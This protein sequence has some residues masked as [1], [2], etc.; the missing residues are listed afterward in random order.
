LTERLY[1]EDSYATS[2]RSRVYAVTQRGDTYATELQAT[3]F[4]PESGSQPSDTG[5][6]DDLRIETVVEDGDTVLHISTRRPPFGPG[7][8]VDGRIDWDRRFA[9]MQQHT[10]QHILS[11]A[12]VQELDARTVSSKLGIESS[13][14]DV[15]CLGLDWDEIERAER[16][17]NAIVFANLAVKV[18]SARAGEVDGL[19]Y[20]LELADQILAREM[21][22][23]VEIEGFDK[24]PCGG[25]HCRM[26]GEV[27]LIKVLR[28]EKVRET[29]RVEFVCG[30]LA[31]VDYFWKNR[32]VVDLARQLTTK[33][34][35]VPGR[36]QNLLENNKE[37][38]FRI[39]GLNKKLLRYEAVELGRGARRV[40]NVRLVCTYL[41]RK[42]EDD[43]R[44]LAGCLVGGAG[45][46][47]LLACGKTAVHFIFAR[48]ADVTCDMRK[49]IE[50]ACRVVGGR[51]GGKPDFCEGG[52]K[53]V[54]RVTEALGEAEHLLGEMLN[55]IA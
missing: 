6:I 4:Y 23:V 1:H 27:G 11:Q 37:L 16:C 10:G 7:D 43:I 45:T 9:N 17:A 34:A 30:R 25:T 41:E 5:S 33:D 12:F 20:K 46:V 52:G 21:L 31:E 14:I 2:F 26:T 50:A 47:A 13:T 51:G 49:V 8:E 15:A 44:R 54:G 40:G 29:T 32:F 18:Y 35:N 48:S 36:V 19:R 38:K 53:G 55:E 42:T 22:R 28:W 3:L 24:S 39:G